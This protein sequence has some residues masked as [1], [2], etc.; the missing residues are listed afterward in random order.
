MKVGLVDLD[1]SHPAA[2]TPLLRELGHEVVGVWH[3]GPAEEF[4]AAHG[5]PQVFDRLE[6][7]AEAV[8]LVVIGG[9]DWSTHVTRVAPFVAA[10]RAV[11]VDKPF[12]GN[13]ADLRQLVSWA[14][15]GARIS[16]GSSLRWAAPQLDG[17][18]RPEFALVGCSGHELDYGV[19]AYSLLHG[20][21]GPGMTRARW[22]G[23]C[24]QSRVEVGWDDGRTGMVSIGETAARHPFHATVLSGQSV[25]YHEISPDILYRTLLRVVVPYLAGEAPDPMPMRQLVEPELAALAALVSRQQGGRWVSFDDDAMATVEYDGPGFAAAYRAARR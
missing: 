2:F 16:G 19:H 22:L 9:A 21:L 1:T 20:I 13:L 23:G 11:F 14:E 12:A 24:G 15:S 7:M 6:D 5:I 17:D 4:A 10:G 25:S 3:H 18:D 8:D